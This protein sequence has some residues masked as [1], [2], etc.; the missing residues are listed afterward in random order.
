MVRFNL[1]NWNTLL[2]HYQRIEPIYQVEAAECGF[3]CLAMV[4]SKY[5]TETNMRAFH[6]RYRL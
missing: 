2:G 4:L 1:K 6:S 3:A 5:G